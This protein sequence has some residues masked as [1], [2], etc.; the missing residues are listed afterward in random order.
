[1]RIGANCYGVD[2][3]MTTTAIANNFRICQSFLGAKIYDPKDPSADLSA[4]LYQV[5]GSTFDLMETYS[6]IWKPVNGSDTVSIFGFRYDVGL[7]PVHVNLDRMIDKFRL[8]VKELGFI[9]EGFMSKDQVNF[10]RRLSESSKE[11]FSIPDEVWV[12]IVYSFAIAV[13]KK[14]VNKEHL[15]KSLTPLYI[16]KTASFVIETWESGASEVEEKI[17][18]L[19]KMFENRKSFLL[20]NWD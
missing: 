14:T 3:W 20:E 16:G 13:H 1:M 9:W 6:E 15:L 8:G 2:I 10:P 5:V 18:R 4:M 19:C 12:K 11:D 7:E 17:E